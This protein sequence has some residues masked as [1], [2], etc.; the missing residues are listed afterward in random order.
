MIIKGNR[1]ILPLDVI[2]YILK[3][4]YIGIVGTLVIA[5]LFTGY[6]YYKD[7]KNVA[8]QA[9]LDREATEYDINEF[10]E[11]E[12]NQAQNAVDAYNTL[13]KTQNYY[14]NS[15]IQKVDPF[16]VAQ[17][18]LYY[19]I[20][21]DSSKLDESQ[22]GQENNL[23]MVV[24]NE[25]MYYIYRGNLGT[26]V[27]E[28]IGVDPQYITELVT[29]ENDGNVALSVILRAS[30]I[31]PG[32][33]D[34]VIEAMDEYN[35]EMNKSYAIHT[36]TL[37]DRYEAVM[38]L[39]DFYNRQRNSTSELNTCTNNLNNILNKMSMKQVAYYNGE[40]GNSFQY[41]DQETGESP[42][43]YVSMGKKGLIKNGIIG[44][45]AGVIVVCVIEMFLYMYSSMII[46]NTDY[47][48]SLGMVLLGEDKD[49]IQK[50]LAIAKIKGLCV[51]K[52]ITT[53]TIA[54]TAKQLT[55]DKL[56]WLK[57]ALSKEGITAN[58][59]GIIKDSPE[60]IDRTI[61]SKA[62]VLCEIQGVSK[63]KDVDE[64]ASLC[65][66]CGLELLGVINCARVK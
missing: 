33:A 24:R 52:D 29:V 7:K 38:R 4:W 63:Y 25:Y 58:I 39:D 64:E 19:K 36:A 46:S 60:K 3:K 66:D 49:E 56:R 37:Q 34:A 40:T 12:L 2:K 48:M 35:T 30:D 65:D 45:A 1:V 10:T 17:T 8:N 15:Y 44:A 27:A 62:M 42:S 53:L 14:D 22:K 43:S 59:E 5:V 11:E 32:F 20:V 26:D 41:L 57:D 61:A 47:T 18:T 50:K 9:N 54:T 23:A 55:E 16:A 21:V 28:K 6:A 51:K 31:V 13:A